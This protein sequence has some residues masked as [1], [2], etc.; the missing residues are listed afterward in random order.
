MRRIF[1]VIG[2]MVGLSALGVV[3]QADDDDTTNDDPALTAQLTQLE[4]ITS[5]VRGLSYDGD[6]V[7]NF[8]SRED[9]RDLVSFGW[10]TSGF[11][12]LV[13][14][15]RA[16][17]LLPAE[18]DFYGTLDQMNGEN[19]GGFYDL[20]TEE[21]NVVLDEGDTPGATLT[22]EEQIVYVHEFTHALQD[23]RFDLSLLMGAHGYATD[24][25][26]AVLAL[27]EGDAMFTQSQ[28]VRVAVE[29]SQQYRPLLSIAL[30]GENTPPGLDIPLILRAELYLPYLDGMNFVKT[31]HAL[32][33]WEAVNAAYDDPPESTEQILHPERYLAGDAPRRVFLGESAPALKGTDW[34]R[35]RFDTLGEFY[36]RQYLGTGLTRPAVDAAATGWGGDR[37]ALYYNEVTDQRAWLLEI[38]WDTPQ[39]AEEFAGYFATFAE[40]RTANTDTLTDEAV[41]CWGGVEIALCLRH[42]G[43]VTTLASAPMINQAYQLVESQ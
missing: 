14:F 31:L 22:A 15:Y 4:L 36:L 38:V 21:I 26:A 27:I 33:G 6:A 1:I 29:K 13:E 43:D 25:Y 12:P 35:I 23:Q 32:G 16:F 34:E 7:T 5:Q 42:A 9:A 28:F 11:D 39:D 2:L 37:Y 30:L 10:V 40:A 20:I 8:L 24:R 3:A 17:D 41:I 18:F 19:V